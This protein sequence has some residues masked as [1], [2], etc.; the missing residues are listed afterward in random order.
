MSIL[1]IFFPHLF[2]GR[3]KLVW[4][5]GQ[6]FEVIRDSLEMGDLSQHRNL[7]ILKEHI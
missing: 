7:L 4:I 2:T 5:R 1:D 6:S 3:G